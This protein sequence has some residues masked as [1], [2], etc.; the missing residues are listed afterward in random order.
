MS[1]ARPM[2]PF[3]RLGLD[4][5]PLF[6]FFAAYSL[7]D[8]FFATGALMAAA[9]V[10]VAANFAI[11]RKVAPMPLITL[12]LV[13]IFGGLTLWLD[14]ENFIKVKPTILYAIFAT[15]LLAGLATGRL[16][17]KSL[18]AQSLRMPEEAWR[19]LTW[20]WAA[21]FL[22]LAAINEIVWRNFTDDTWVAFKVWGVI[23]LTFL[24]VASQTPYISRHQIEDDAP[25]E[26]G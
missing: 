15:V 4:L 2:N 23:T 19:T 5:G 3:L 7:S 20:R 6:V 8:I 12:V 1:A 14:N 22:S 24:F 10:S 26:G 16:F 25:A 18:L 11:E 9:T 21:F 13:L 17:L